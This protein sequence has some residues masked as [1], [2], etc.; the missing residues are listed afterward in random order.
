MSRIRV[1]FELIE[2]ELV[3]VSEC[4]VRFEG[5]F[6]KV[7]FQS[8]QAVEKDLI[9]STKFVSIMGETHFSDSFH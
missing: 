5:S 9:L 8:K 4:P 6:V 1:P 2:S 3:S 7:F